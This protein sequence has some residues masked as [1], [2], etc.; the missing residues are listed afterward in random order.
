MHT[1]AAF[2]YCWLLLKVTI[3]VESYVNW[4]WF[5]LWH[6][7]FKGLA[8]RAKLSINNCLFCCCLFMCL[9]YFL[10][11]STDFKNKHW[12]ISR[13]ILLERECSVIF[14]FCNMNLSKSAKNCFNKSICDFKFNTFASFHMYFVSKRQPKIWKK[15]TSSATEKTLKMQ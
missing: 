3:C 13:Q 10:L 14:I 2:Y 11:V 6:P 7:H 9:V 8:S 1:V 4:I 5:H 12:K 15:I